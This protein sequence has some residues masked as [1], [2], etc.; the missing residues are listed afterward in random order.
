MYAYISRPTFRVF[1][2]G[3]L[4]YQ[5]IYSKIKKDS[6]YFSFFAEW[7]HEASPARVE[8]EA[9][10]GDQAAP[11]ELETEGN[12]HQETVQ[13][14]LQDSDQAV[15]GSQGS[16]IYHSNALLPNSYWYLTPCIIT[17]FWTIL[18]SY[19]H[20]SFVHQRVYFKRL[21]RCTVIAKKNQFR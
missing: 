3:I 5:N 13:G 11:E 9:R 21:N 7:V 1:V 14:H 10:P 18:Q 6:N 15:Q 12:A 17:L 4:R 19:A 16:G 8:E 20:I 2:I